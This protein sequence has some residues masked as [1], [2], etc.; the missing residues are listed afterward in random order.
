MTM[1]L[2]TLLLRVIGVGLV[3]VDPG[4]EAVVG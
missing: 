3:Q 4:S 2:M 1:L